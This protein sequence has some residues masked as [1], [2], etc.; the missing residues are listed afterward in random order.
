MI[1]QG[2]LGGVGPQVGRTGDGRASRD[3]ILASMWYNEVE[4]ARRPLLRKRERK[5]RA[6]QGR[7][8]GNTQAGRPDGKWHRNIPPFVA[9]ATKGKGE[10]V[11]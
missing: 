6:P 4:W 5:V 2:T 10:M 11:R 1:W 8:L 9:K 7:A 3:P